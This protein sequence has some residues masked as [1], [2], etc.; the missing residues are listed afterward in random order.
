MKKKP[1]LYSHYPETTQDKLSVFLLGDGMIRG[2]ILQGTGLLRQMRANHSLGILETLVLGRTAIGALLISGDQKEAGRVRIQIECGGPVKGVTA[3]ADS[4]GNVTGYLMQNPIPMDKPMESY[5]LSPYFGPG[6]LSVTKVTESATEPATG[7]IILEHGNVG[8]DLAVYYLNSEQIPTLFDLSIQFTKEGAIAGAGGL[9]LQVLPG[10]SEELL[11]SLEKRIETMTSPG[12]FF[13]DGGTGEE[14][15]LENFK[16]FTPR[17]LEEKPA[18]FYCSCNRSKFQ[19]YLKGLSEKD[20]SHLA[21]DQ[22]IEVL[23]HNCGT[24]DH[25]DREEFT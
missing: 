9:F 11:I 13:S 25:F 6:F 4:N 10:A 12:Q 19:T 8:Q 5:D 24:P 2:R 16:D 7:Q 23:C 14:F 18:E 3:E 17:F 15:I 1:L 21:E 22:K 20:R